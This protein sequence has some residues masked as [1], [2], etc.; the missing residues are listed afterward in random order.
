VLAW[1]LLGFYKPV[2]MGDGLHPIVNT[3]KNGS[4][5]PL[6]F[7]IFAGLTELTTT[8]NVAAFK[9]Q[10]VSC[11]AFVDALSDPIDVTTTGGTTLRYDSTSGQFVQNWQTPKRAGTC[12]VVTMTTLD[13]STTTANF[14][15]K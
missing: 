14:Q 4:T 13:G 5:V 3:V 12:W 9:Q 6:K 11:S 2:D 1:R 7:E 10:Q 8:G 15:L